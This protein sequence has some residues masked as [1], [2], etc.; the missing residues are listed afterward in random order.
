MWWVKCI[1]CSRGR[2]RETGL[3]LFIFVSLDWY[4]RPIRDCISACKHGGG[5][6]AGVR[7]GISGRNPLCWL[8]TERLS[9]WGYADCEYWANNAEN[10]RV[11][12]Y[13]ILVC[14]SLLLGKCLSDFL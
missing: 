2:E 14:V 11:E 4:S 12:D 9:E 10:T 7:T 5:D 3:L 6:K 13:R 1:Y 8:P